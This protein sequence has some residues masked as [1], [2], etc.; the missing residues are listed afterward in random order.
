[1]ARYTANP[2]TPAGN[3]LSVTDP[4]GATA[5]GIGLLTTGPSDTYTATQQP[6]YNS[7]A[8]PI[9]DKSIY[10]WDKINLMGNSKAWDKVDT[11]LVQIDQIVLDT[12]QQTLAAQVT[13]LRED[14][15]RL[16]NQPMGRATSGSSRLT[17]TPTTL[18]ARRIL[19]SAG[20]I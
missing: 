13:Y 3:N 8:R 1:M 15:F 4:F 9:S 10:N 20:R 12:A 18:M 7:L 2:A 16:E 6:L 19:T 14:A 17:P 11:Y 5:T